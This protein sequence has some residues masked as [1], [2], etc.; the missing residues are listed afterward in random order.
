MIGWGNLWG[1]FVRS[2]L[3]T[4]LTLLPACGDDTQPLVDGAVIDAPV[5]DAPMPDAAPL[6]A[7]AGSRL[8]SSTGLYADIGS[9]T[10]APDLVE[11]TPNYVLWADGAEK[12]RWIRLPAGTQIDTTDFDHWQFPIGTQFFKEFSLD[13]K[14]LE[15]RLIERTGP[16]AL[17]YF[18]GAFV[19]LED[20]S[21]AVFVP[22][23][24]L[25]V[26]GT[27]HDVPS[28]TACF[29]C[30]QGE[31]GRILGF[32]AIQLWRSSPTPSV[33]SLVAQNRLSVPPASAV[34][35]TVP[36]DATARAALGY[37][38][39]N[40]GH[41]HNPFGYVNFQNMT[42]RLDGADRTVDATTTYRTTVGV[43]LRDFGYPG[44]TYRIVAGHPEESAIIL[45]MSHRGDRVAMP[46][47]ATEL[48]DPTGIQGVTDWISTLQ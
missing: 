4:M 35:F 26:R 28:T 25:D 44:Y 33:A 45:R 24:Q 21:D 17:D 12:H 42:L 19:W 27:M 29:I 2:L 30:H 38:H 47:I 37:L 20:E 6:D 39:A 22:G 15:T 41:C 48:M 40:C 32:S 36:G 16:G 5:V 1:E 18:L 43:A 3:I 46:P 31:A 8:L 7:P 10:I 34:D 14:R 23:G 11:F 9:K 13:G